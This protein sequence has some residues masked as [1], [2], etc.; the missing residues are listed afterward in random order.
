MAGFKAT[1][2][3]NVNN[4]FNYNYI[5]DATCSSGPG[6]R[7]WEDAYGVFYSFGRTYSLRMKIAF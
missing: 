7:T 3:G 4:L 5:V 1:L 6:K 2:S